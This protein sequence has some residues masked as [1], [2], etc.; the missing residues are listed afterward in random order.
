MIPPNAELTR[1][2]AIKLAGVDTDKVKAEILLINQN[3]GNAKLDALNKE[4][5]NELGR[6]QAT[7][8]SM[9]MNETVGIIRANLD[10]IKANIKNKGLES[11][12][13]EGT[14]NYSIE[15]ARVNIIATKLNSQLTQWNINLKPTELEELKTKIWEAQRKVHYWEMDNQR[16]WEKL[17]QDI[18][19]KDVDK[20][21]KD[22]GLDTQKRGQT[23]QFIS[24]AIG[25]AVKSQQ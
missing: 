13:R 6:I 14:L 25:S 5:N 8:Q 2:N 1:A 11:D 19:L 16:D 18:Y 7:I 4:I 15:Q 12:L 3:T 21:M 22:K 9:T 17:G 23:L 20:Y 24:S 10:E